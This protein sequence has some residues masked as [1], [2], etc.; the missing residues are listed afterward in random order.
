MEHETAVWTREDGL[1]T[2]RD[3][4][5]RTPEQRRRDAKEVA[6]LMQKA[7]PGCGLSAEGGLLRGIQDDV[8]EAAIAVLNLSDAPERW[9]G[10]PFWVDILAR[11]LA[12]AFEVTPADKAVMIE[13][14]NEYMA[15]AGVMLVCCP[16]RGETE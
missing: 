9:D 13:R 3:I 12:E 14:V 8:G 4:M 16:D 7:V 10:C 6:A 15:D 1:A 2:L 5:D 11:Y